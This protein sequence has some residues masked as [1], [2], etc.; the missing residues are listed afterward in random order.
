MGYGLICV[1]SP[2]GADALARLGRPPFPA[3]ASIGPG[4]SARLAALGIRAEIEPDENTGQGLARELFKRGLAGA[5]KRILLVRG[6]RAGDALPDALRAA[7][8]EVVD[9]VAYRTVLAGEEMRPEIE[10]VIAAGVD[11]IAVTSGSSAEAWVKVLGAERAQEVFARAPG[12]AIGPQAAQGMKRHKLP[13]AAIAHPH[14][15]DGLVGAV[16]AVVRAVG[17]NRGEKEGK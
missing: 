6:D 3:V 15:I 4:T 16:V 8:A 13:V 14:T 2:N 17:E 9:I 12:I 11:A 10:E 7:G 1:T 5:G